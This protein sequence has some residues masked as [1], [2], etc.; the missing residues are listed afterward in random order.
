MP[1]SPTFRKVPLT[2]DLAV[3]LAAEAQALSPGWHLNFSFLCPL[4]VPLGGYPV[5]VLNDGQ[6]LF[7]DAVGSL[8]GASWQAGATVANL[9]GE[10]RIPRETPL[11]H[12]LPSHSPRLRQFHRPRRLS[13]PRLC[14]RGAALQ[15]KPRATISRPS[16][17]CSRPFSGFLHPVDFS[18]HHPRNRSLGRLALFRLLPVQ[19]GRRITQ[20]SARGR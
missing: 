1:A 20:H 12:P 11:P 6:N 16:L 3:K 4:A 9:I 2:A 13:S 17:P 18:L 5:V 8:S 10:G 15:R 14:I 19:A 7:G